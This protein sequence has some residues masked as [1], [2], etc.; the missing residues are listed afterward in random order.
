ML[1]VV[2]LASTLGTA[3][4]DEKAMPSPGLP[5]QFMTVGKI[6]LETKTLVLY[7]SCSVY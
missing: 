2:S 4:A 1:A 5:P 3:I 7:L 6:D